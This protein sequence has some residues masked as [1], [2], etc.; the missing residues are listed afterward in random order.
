[1]LVV[2]DEPD[3]AAFLTALLEDAGY[4]ARSAPTA[5]AALGQLRRTPPD[6][7]CVDIMMPGRSGLSLYQQL[8]R[9]VSFRDIPVIIVSAFSRALD[10]KGER[11]QKL[12]GFGE[13]PEPEAFIEKPVEPEVFLDAV[14]SVLQRGS[15]S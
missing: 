6:L 13:M 3:I 12:A 9:D 1:M 8:R 15:R 11:F 4:E 2:D 5:E 10:F 7:L 14:E